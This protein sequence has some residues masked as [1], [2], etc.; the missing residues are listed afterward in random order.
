MFVVERARALGRQAALEKVGML[1]TPWAGPL[2]RAALPDV[3]MAR[4]D[5]DNRALLQRIEGASSI[6]IVNA[7]GPAY[8]RL[9]GGSGNKAQVQIPKH[10][11][12]DLPAEIMAHELGHHSHGQSIPGKMTQRPLSRV[13]YNSAPFVG[14]GLGLLPEDEI[15]TPQAMA[16]AVAPTLPTLFNE[17]SASIRGHGLLKRHGATPAQLAAGRK[18]LLKAFATY[19]VLPATAAL[20]PV[21]VR[22]GKKLLHSYDA[23]K[24]KTD[25]EA[26][27]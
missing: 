17:A 7:E 6:P 27:K 5:A 19:G 24:K 15:S 11:R 22:A 10:L 20:E 8:M 26:K 16:G 4:P 21:A 9:P 18:N 13:A 1:I 2:V 25:T 12:K 23:K 14:L 3:E